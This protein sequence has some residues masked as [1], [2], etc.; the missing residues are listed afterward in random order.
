MSAAHRDPTTGPRTLDP[1]KIGLSLDTY[2][3]DIISPDFHQR[4]KRRWSYIN[5]RNAT[6][7]AWH[8]L[9]N[10]GLIYSDSKKK[11]DI[12]NNQFSS[13]FTQEPD[14]ELPDLGVCQHPDGHNPSN[15]PRNRHTRPPIQTTYR[16]ES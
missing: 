6:T 16:S 2:I 5:R 12:V 14:D 8:L 3:R 4:P 9:D 13:V 7:M 10:D 11:A 1:N 15:H